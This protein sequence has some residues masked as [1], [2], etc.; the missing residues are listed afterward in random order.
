[1]RAFLLT[2][3]VA[4][5]LAAGGCTDLGIGNRCFDTGGNDAGTKG[6][7]LDSP[8]LECMSRLCLL[9]G[10]STGAPVRSTCTARCQTD[11]DCSSAVLADPNDPN[12]AMSLQCTS[13]FVCAVATTVGPFKCQKV[14]VCKDDLVS[15]F[16]GDPDGGVVCPT[17]CQDTSGNCLAM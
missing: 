14:C 11:D 1:M 17:F 3:C 5:A 4:G 12:S 9:Q 13:Q 6:T 7:R 10:S 2:A 15:G 8:S 16:N